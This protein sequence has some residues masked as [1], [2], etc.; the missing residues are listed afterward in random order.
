MTGKVLGQFFTPPNIKNM[1]I[2]LV[3]PQIKKDGTIEKIFDPAM[4]TGGFLISSL[5][6]LVKQSKEKEINLNWNFITNEGLGGREAEP[7]TYQLAISN[8]LISSGY[9]FNVI[10]NLRRFK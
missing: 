6:H 10:E 7:D 8:M 5:R 1:M 9:M 4:G 2:K 3:N